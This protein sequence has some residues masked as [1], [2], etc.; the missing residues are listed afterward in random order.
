[1]S[2]QTFVY[3][4]TTARF[5]KEMHDVYRVLRDDWPVYV[6]PDGSYVL[7]RFADV[8]NAVH[9]W[10]TFS[11]TCAEAD[12]LMPQMIYMD[13]PRHTALRSLVS[14]AFTP[15]R[16]AD[17]E[18][19]IREVARG[20]LDDITARGSCDLVHSFAAPLPS[21]VMADLIGVPSKHREAFRSWTE[22]FLEVTGPQ[23]IAERATNIYRLFG[24]LLA[25]RRRNP[26]GRPHE[27][28]LGG[29]GRR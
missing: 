20:L 2:Q 6:S 14:R 7:S 10:K 18:G 11:S 22:A 13:P 5:Q 26:T 29:R 12:E 24:E 16:V 19:R 17:L 9:D 8:W 21:T 27:R 25:E 15:R 23:D 4:P 28:A 1:M 3:D